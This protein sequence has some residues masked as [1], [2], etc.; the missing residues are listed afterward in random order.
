[1]SAQSRPRRWALGALGAAAGLFVVVLIVVSLANAGRPVAAPSPSSASPPSATNITFLATV[2]AD[3]STD[4]LATMGKTDDDVVTAARYV[5]ILRKQG[6]HT[7]QIAKEQALAP[8]IITG[9]AGHFVSASIR[10]YCPDR[11]EG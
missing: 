4:A 9:R 2:S 11:T 5:C 3:V 10:H 1:M 7:K 6:E 8:W